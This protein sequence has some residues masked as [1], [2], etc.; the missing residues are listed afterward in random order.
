[1]EER[2]GRVGD[3]GVGARYGL[4]AV[5]DG[6]TLGCIR[7]ANLAFLALLGSSRPRLAARRYGLEAPAATAVA[8]LDPFARRAVAALPYTL[9]NMRFEDRDFW[10][11]ITRDAAAPGSASLSEEATFAR[12]AIFLAWH[13][14]QGEDLAPAMVLGMGPAV[15]EVWRQL[16][17]AAIDHA[18]TRALPALRARWVEHPRFWPRLAASGRAGA[19]KATVELRDLGLQLL[20]AQGL[21]PIAAVAEPL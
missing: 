21:A 12:T 2:L 18:A 9:F 17:L 8:E 13:L 11:A 6:A 5:L 19:R 16:P 15:V 3:G 4:R 7:E 14:V 1:M 10:R 20:A